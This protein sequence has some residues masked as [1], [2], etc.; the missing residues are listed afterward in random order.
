M[1]APD[2]VMGNDGKFYLY[3]CMA[4]DFGKGG[5]GNPISVA[6][7]DTPDGKYEYLGVVKN[8]DGTLFMT[9]ANFDPAVINDDGVI[10]LYSGTWYPIVE[11]RNI[12]SNGILDRMESIIFGKSKEHIKEL[13]KKGDA[14]YGPHHMELCNDMMTLKT[15]PVRILPLHHENTKF[16]TK[17]G[18]GFF[19]G[20]SI[21]KIGK[22][23]YFIYSSLNNH[24]LCYATSSY[25]DRDFS[26]GGIIVSNGDIGF[27]GR[28]AKDR[29]NM[30]GN[31][32]GS[33][34]CING[35]WY[36]FYHR[37]THK[38]NYSRQGCAEKIQIAQD[39]SIAQ[40]EITSAGLSGG[41]LPGE[42]TYPAAICCNLTNG[43]MPH[44][45][46]KK[47]KEALPHVG[48]GDGQQYIKE[49]TNGTWIGYKYF[50]FK[51]LE[52]IRLR[53]RGKAVGKMS[54]YTVMKKDE[55]CCI[56]SV[57]IS[58]HTQWTDYIFSVKNTV[59]ITPLYLNYQGEKEIELLEI[60][61]IERGRV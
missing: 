23:Y 54:V 37:Q 55:S 42:G 41:V 11:K 15:S 13:R 3:Y 30:T 9:Y 6:V 48:S 29:L 2:V 34:E 43:H 5:Y 12:F 10:R 16:N 52:K 56:G 20:S 61:L 46:N 27:A 8:S 18:H 47:L 58:E 38:S 57:H 49:I 32:H 50:D 28:A 53:I 1:Y 45:S 17:E 60:E 4:G 39:G 44:G 35:Q 14:V 51:N 59:G 36:V 19:E 33:I 31:T 26:Y 24:E 7:C 22:T 25:P 21:R 40:V